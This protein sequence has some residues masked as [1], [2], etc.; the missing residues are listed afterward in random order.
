MKRLVLLASLLVLTSILGCS[1]NDC[2][3]CPTQTDPSAQPYPLV[4]YWEA[5]ACEGMCVDDEPWIH[6]VS[7]RR[8]GT[9]SEYDSVLVT[10]ITAGTYEYVGDALNLTVTDPGT[11]TTAMWKCN[12][13]AD[14]MTWCRCESENPPAWV[15]V[16]STAF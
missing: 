13:S 1:D 12:I 7:F 2:P 6:A 3:T 5:V 14:S 15:F 16:R 4:G 10:R 9:F 11:T 8:D